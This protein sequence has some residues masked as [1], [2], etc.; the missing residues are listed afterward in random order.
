MINT[1]GS[2]PIAGLPDARP[3]RGAPVTGG[4]RFASVFEKTLR[5]PQEVRF[6]AHATQRLG[7]RGI[8]LSEA[9]LGRVAKAIDDA[10]AKGA[11]E[12]VLLM[13]RLAL[14]VSVA[15]RTVITA[16]EPDGL[17][18]AVFTN[19]DSVV[20]VGSGEAASHNLRATGP[21]PVWGGP[22]AANR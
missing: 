14:V 1:I 18:N 2:P 15:N 8:R 21:D 12:S 9:E 7:E 6:S 16:L 13:D 5:K 11:R 22:P 17:Q 20:V 10:A 3:I 4:R 19:I